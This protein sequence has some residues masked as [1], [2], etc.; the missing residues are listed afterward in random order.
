MSGMKSKR[1]RAEEARKILNWGLRAFEKIELFGDGEVI[2]QANVYGGA[3]PGVDVIS[4]GPLDIYLPIGNRDKLKARI[5]YTGPLMPPVSKGQEV[6]K[7]RVWIGDELS[8]ETPLYAG[9]SVEKGDLT[10]RATDAL[11]ELLFGWL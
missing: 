2:G 11:K 7:L 1:Q 9:E 8:Q 6:A 3:T 4:K 5:A 10:R